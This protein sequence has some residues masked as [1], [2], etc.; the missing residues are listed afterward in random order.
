MAEAFAKKYGKESLEAS[1]ADNKPADHINQVVVD[2]LKEIGID[3]AMNKPKLITAKMTMN[4]DLVVTMG[5]NTQGIC[6]GP[7]FCADGG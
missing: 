7:F 6:P 4:M 1:S 5:C 2:A 3:I